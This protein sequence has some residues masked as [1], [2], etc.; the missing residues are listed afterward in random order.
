MSGALF[1]RTVGDV[2]NILALEHVNVTVPDQRAAE[3]FYVEGLGLTRDPH[4]DFGGAN[5]WINAGS[6]QF[7]L[8]TA[9][10]PQVLRGTVGLVTPS[11][12]RVRQGLDRIGADFEPGSDGTLLVRCPWGNRI[13]VHQAGEA[14]GSMALG[15]PYVELDVAAGTAAGI[16]RFYESVLGAPASVRRTP[17]GAVARVGVGRHQALVFR[18]GADPPPPYDGHH[19]AVYVAQFSR[20]H[21]R[22]AAAGLITA[23]TGEHEYRFC[24]VVDPDSGNVLTEIEHEV[25]SLR[26]PMYGRPLVNPGFSSPG[27]SSPGFF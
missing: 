22:L 11:L 13:T 20:P 7:H 16:A 21:A 2:G 24:A 19:V 26:H 27:F 18:E 23:E 4:M 1:N 6:Q 5:V 9:S 15:I 8:P 14:F 3:R 17:G 25:R 12:E 10:A